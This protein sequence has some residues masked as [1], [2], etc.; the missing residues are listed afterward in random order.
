MSIANP[1]TRRAVLATGM[2]AGA[3]LPALASTPRFATTARLD[4]DRNP[5]S[6]LKMPDPVPVRADTVRVSGGFLWYSDTGGSG[7]PIVLLHP[8]TGSGHVWGHQQPVLAHAGYRV[9]A[10]S[11]R[12]F[13]GSSAIDPGSP[14]QADD[15]LAEL[16]NALGIDRF[17][18]VGTA[19]GAFAAASFA[20]TRPERLI[21]LTLACTIVAMTDSQRV[22]SLAFLQEPW[23]QA[24]PHHFR[25]LGPSY[26]ALDQEGVD[27]WRALQESSRGD[28]PPASQ[29]AGKPVSLATLAR[30]KMPTLLIAG[31]ADL[32]APPPLARIMAAAMPGSELTIIP[33]CGHSAYWERPDIFN[34]VLLDFMRRNR[35]NARNPSTQ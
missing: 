11:R 33:E 17:H 31:D 19:A 7:E 14:G 1:V 8:N 24:L 29:P 15:D 32:Y 30:L 26:R 13:R 6:I 23:W 18:A 5:L 21:S 27:R 28:N 9:I 3:N 4:G 22:G 25:E 20:A 12:G 10:Y 16:A 34:N 2:I 35:G